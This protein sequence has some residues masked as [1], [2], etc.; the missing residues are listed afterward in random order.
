MNRKRLKQAL[1]T[2]V[3]LAVLLVGLGYNSYI[4]VHTFTLSGEGR[5]KS[6]QIQPVSATVKVTGTADTDVVFTDIESGKTYTIG[7]ITSGMN[8]SI[9]LEQGKWY[10]VEG[11]GKLTLRPVN[12]RVE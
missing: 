2:A 3:P 5:V 10:T 6:E 9:Q 4:R 1:C 11:S 12:V 8:G 7:Y